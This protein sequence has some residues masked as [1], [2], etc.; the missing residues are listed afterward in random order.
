MPKVDKSILDMVQDLF[1]RYEQEMRESNY[2]QESKRVRIAYTRQFVQWL[3]GEY[4]PGDF[5][6][7]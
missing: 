4:S 1:D 6:G 3:A 7:W 2:T 5:E